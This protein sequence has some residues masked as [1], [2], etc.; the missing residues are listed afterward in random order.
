M[1]GENK[2]GNIVYNNVFPYHENGEHTKFYPFLFIKSRR[3]KDGTENGTKATTMLFHYGDWLTE[4]L[5]AKDD[6]VHLY[7]NEIWIEGFEG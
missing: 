2:N 6:Q 7:H 1:D 4:D 3:V 5:W